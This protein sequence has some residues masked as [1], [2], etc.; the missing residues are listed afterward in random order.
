[1]E[2][3]CQITFTWLNVIEVKF[4]LSQCWAATFQASLSLWGLIWDFAGLTCFA[5]FVRMRSLLGVPFVLVVCFFTLSS[6]PFVCDG[7]HT[8][9]IFGVGSISTVCQCDGTWWLLL[10]GFPWIPAS[11]YCPRLIFHLAKHLS[12]AQHLV[13]S[14]TNT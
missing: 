11:C 8:V 14:L 12:Q 1:M 10:S 13:S 4:D 6:F 2:S 5:S 3:T 9:I 7:K